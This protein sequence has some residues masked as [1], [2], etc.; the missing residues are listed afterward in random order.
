MI[1]LWIETRIPIA[2]NSSGLHLQP[3]YKQCYVIFI[4]SNKV[5]STASAVIQYQSLTTFSVIVLIT[6]IP[7]RS[8]TPILHRY[9]ISIESV[10]PISTEAKIAQLGERMTEDHKVRC[11]I[12]LLGAFFSLSFWMGWEE[13]DAYSLFFIFKQRSHNCSQSRCDEFAGHTRVGSLPLLL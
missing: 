8:F 12:H 4:E 5:Q 13:N 3:Y 6:L 2:I 7:P 9:P 1:S 11:S 10:D